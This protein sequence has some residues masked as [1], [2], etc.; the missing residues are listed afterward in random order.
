LGRLYVC[1]APRLNIYR[2]LKRR[3]LDVFENLSAERFTS[4]IVDAEQVEDFSG[5]APAAVAVTFYSVRYRGQFRPLRAERSNPA[6]NAA[7]DCFVG[8]A[9]RNDEKGSS[10]AKCSV[11]KKQKANGVATVR[12]VSLVAWKKQLAAEAALPE[13]G[14]VSVT[15]SAR[16]VV[17]VIAGIGI[18]RIGLGHMLRGMARRFGVALRKAGCGRRE[19][20]NGAEGEYSHLTC[21]DDLRR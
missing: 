3:Y 4:G 11:D 16:A 19:R 9:P 6:F 7:L 21:H 20:E 14:L 18:N 2:G 8:C 12:L 1:H 5:N 10:P 17:V 13:T 15:K